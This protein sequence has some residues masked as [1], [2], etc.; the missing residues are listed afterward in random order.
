MEKEYGIPYIYTDLPIG[1]VGIRNFIHQ[2]KVNFHTKDYGNYE[3][4]GLE[5][6]NPYVNHQ[7]LRG[8]KVYL[9]LGIGKVK[10]VAS[11]VKE[12]GGQVIGVLVPQLDSYVNTVLSD[13][14]GEYSG[15]SITV[16]N[17]RPFE[18]Y[19]ALNRSKADIYITDQN[20]F[21][22]LNG[23]SV[24]AVYVK[25][26]SLLGFHGIYDFNNL[27]EKLLFSKRH[28]NW[29]GVYFEPVYELEWI[30]KPEYIR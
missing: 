13:L 30:M 18:L 4:K 29:A 25:N 1:T 20:D 23:M 8:Q 24:P 15:I 9:N 10:T 12:L 22:L 11:L 7:V 2:L 21:R 26:T 14:T 28:V 17:G 19:R 27:V 5:K 16:S 6:I 3:L